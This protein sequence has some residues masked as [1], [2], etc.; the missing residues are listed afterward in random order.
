MAKDSHILSTKNNSVF[1][2]FMLETNNV[3]NFEQLGTGGE[4]ITIEDITHERRARWL[5][6]SQHGRH[7]AGINQKHR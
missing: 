3:V 1:V 4:E 6:L 2:I 5:A 7:P